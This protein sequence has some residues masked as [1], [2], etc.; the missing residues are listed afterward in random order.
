MRL[1][2]SAGQGGAAA[3]LPDTRAAVIWRSIAAL[4]ASVTMASL[5]VISVGTL[6]VRVE[7]VSV[8]AVIDWHN[9]VSGVTPARSPWLQNL[10]IALLGAAFLYLFHRLSTSRM[11][12]HSRTMTGLVL[13]A[14]TVWAL[15]TTAFPDAGGVNSPDGTLLTWMRQGSLSSAVHVVA[16]CLVVVNGFQPIRRL[17]RERRVHR[18]A[19]AE[20]G[21]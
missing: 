7:A 10:A 3:L 14:F 8:G 11:W 18:A 20:P 16:T 5:F 2:T 12:R 1:K 9:Q 19:P 15:S 6:E 4:G 13:W 21:T 17:Q